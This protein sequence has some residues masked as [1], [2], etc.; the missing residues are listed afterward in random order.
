MSVPEL[1]LMCVLFYLIGSVPV[2]YILFKRKTGKNLTKSGSGNLGALNTY[3]SSGSKTLGITVLI[4]DFMK[5]F[6]P[7]FLMYK[8]SGF[9]PSVY[10]LPVIFL[11]AGHNFNVWLKFN[12]G[13]GLATAAGISAVFS[14]VTL[15]IWC[16]LFIFSFGIK[17]NVHFGNISASVLLSVVIYVLQPYLAQF[18]HM[19]ANHFGVYFP[20][21]VIICLLIL[22][23]HIGPF[24]AMIKNK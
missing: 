19:I 1:I 20:F 11:V 7:S 10:L 24:V 18:D 16:L 4:F 9:S 21:I 6:I 22:L 2:S 15:F 8:Y 17:R 12:G 23:R 3:E 14:P 13:R 5:G